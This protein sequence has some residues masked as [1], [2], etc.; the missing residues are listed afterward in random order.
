MRPMTGGAGRLFG[1]TERVRSR[2]GAALASV[3]YWRLT[4]RAVSMRWLLVRLNVDLDTVYRRVDGFAA[5]R[6]T[7]TLAP[8][9]RSGIGTRSPPTCARTGTAVAAIDAKIPAAK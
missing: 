3:T 5:V 4:L 9:V 6:K 1:S 2:R 7:N 8:P